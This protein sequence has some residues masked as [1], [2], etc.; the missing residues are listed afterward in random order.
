MS[1]RAFI[2][3]DE[4]LRLANCYDIPFCT[5]VRQ[6]AFLPQKWLPPTTWLWPRI[7]LQSVTTQWSDMNRSGQHPFSKPQDTKRENHHVLKIQPLFKV[8]LNRYSWGAGKQGSGYVSWLRRLECI[9]RR[10]LTMSRLLK[11]LYHLRSRRNS[12]EYSKTSGNFLPLLMIRLVRKFVWEIFNIISSDARCR[13]FNLGL[14]CCCIRGILIE[15]GGS[16]CRPLM[17]PK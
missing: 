16:P 13:I 15:G 3:K 8:W 2:V 11:S 1:S 10:L 12:F 7:P 14:W 17:T 6:K 4:I 5:C 9:S